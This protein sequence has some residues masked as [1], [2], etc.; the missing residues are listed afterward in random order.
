[1]EDIVG[2]AL[3]RARDISRGRQIFAYIPPAFTS[4]MAD[5][6][7]IEDVLINLVQN[8]VKD[9]GPGAPISIFARSTDN[10]IL[11]TV[12]DEGAPLPVYEREHLF[13]RFYRPGRSA[14]EDR[15]AIGLAVCKGIVEAHGGMIWMESQTENGNRFTFSLPWFQESPEGSESGSEKK[16]GIHMH[17]CLS[18][19]EQRRE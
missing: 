3:K 6:A 12:A 17:N 13:E 4:V 11:I 5:F 7:S 9:S 15:T 16:G 1:M 18:V 8:A 19:G 2:V 14:R 10:A